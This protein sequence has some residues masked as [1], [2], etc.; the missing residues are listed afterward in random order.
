MRLPNVCWTKTKP[1][2]TEDTL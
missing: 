1:K 2:A